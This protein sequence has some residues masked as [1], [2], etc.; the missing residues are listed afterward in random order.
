[1]RLADHG[2]A[3][4]AQLFG[5][6]DLPQRAPARE[7]TRH[8]V[9]DREVEVRRGCPVDMA[10]DVEVRIVDPARRVDVQR[11]RADLLPETGRTAQP[12]P[13]VAPQ[14]LEARPGA[15]RRRL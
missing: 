10:G 1:M 7:L 14:L 5:D 11:R 6:V 3:A 9:P 8:A 2:D 4:I 15:V 12:R 13:D